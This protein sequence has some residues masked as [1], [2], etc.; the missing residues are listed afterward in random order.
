MKLR[1]QLRDKYAE[2]LIKMAELQGISPTQLIINLIKGEAS[3]YERS[4][5]HYRQ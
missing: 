2:K 5:Q 1:I 4:K 3:N